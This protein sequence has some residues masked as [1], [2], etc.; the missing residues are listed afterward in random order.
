MGL[1]TLFILHLLVRSFVEGG[2][3]EGPGEADRG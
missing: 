3:S 1:G 2:L